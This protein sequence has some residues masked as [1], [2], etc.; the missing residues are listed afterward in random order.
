VEWVIGIY[1]A[2][3]VFKAFA[4]LSN[5]NP[6]LKPI[7]MSSERHPLRWTVLFTVYVVGWPFARR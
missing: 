6:A 7:W 3:G 2:V 1:L 5:P 4:A